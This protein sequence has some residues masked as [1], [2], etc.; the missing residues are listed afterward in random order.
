MDFA[1][2]IHSLAARLS[3]HKEILETEEATKN[4]L[5]MPF[6]N[7]LGYNVFDPSEVVPE[8]TADVG[9]KKGEKVDYALLVNGDPIILFECKSVKTNL[10]D[11]EYSQLFRYFHVT[12]ARIG[13]L[14]NGVLYRFYTDLD[15]SNK[16]DDKP[17]LEFNLEELKLP[18]LTEL[19]KITKV[20]F[21]LEQ[22]L[23][24]ASDLK[25]SKAIRQLLAKQLVEPSDEFVRF[26]AGEVHPGKRVTQSVL[27]TFRELVKRSFNEFVSDRVSDR[28][29]FALEHETKADVDE[30]AE[31][32]S[33]DEEDDDGI[34]TTEEEKEAHRIIQAILREIVEPD[35]VTM[36]DAKS[37]CSI[38][39]DNNNRKP[40]CRLR[41]NNP[42]KMAVGVFD[43]Q[44]NEEKISID[45]LNK[46]YELGDRFVAIVKY[47]DGVSSSQEA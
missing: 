21:D 7:A 10:D 38:I 18:V 3:K 39:L 40:I 4:A 30:D 42:K 45:S 41:F 16:M 5:V 26:F 43:A 19:K 23:N 13:V 15:E 17:F 6:I 32:P 14:T 20:N 44:K 24:T 28:L 36:R 31:L 9:T 22:L 2:Q 12:K 8:Y 27:L 34:V 25:Y 1:D 33:G 11:A 47:Y 35:R 29:K 46:L 37:Y